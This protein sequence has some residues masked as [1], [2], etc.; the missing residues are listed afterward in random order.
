MINTKLDV[1]Y[2]LTSSEVNKTISGSPLMPLLLTSGKALNRAATIAYNM[3]MLPPGLKMPSPSGMPK[4]FRT[5][6]KTFIS[7][8][9]KAGATS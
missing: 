9:V 2:L 7:T 8:R 5:W 1:I 6:L 4:T 3:D